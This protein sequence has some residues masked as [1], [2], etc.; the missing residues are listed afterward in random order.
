MGVWFVQMLD[1]SL[2]M[3]ANYWRFRGGKWKFLNL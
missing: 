2:R 3:A 1:E